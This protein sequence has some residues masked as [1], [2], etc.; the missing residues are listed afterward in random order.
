MTDF[1]NMGGLRGAGR[2]WCLPKEVVGQGLHGG[3]TQAIGPQAVTVPC[4]QLA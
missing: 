4:P 3:R 1:H 2:A